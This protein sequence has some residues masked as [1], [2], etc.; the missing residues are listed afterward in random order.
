[1]ANPVDI[2]LIERLKSQKWG[3]VASTLFRL[4]ERQANILLAGLEAQPSGK[5][6][7][8]QDPSRWPPGMSSHDIEEAINRVCGCSGCEDCDCVSV[9]NKAKIDAWTTHNSR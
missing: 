2:D 8:P 3:G 9:F 7:K 6:R 5:G 4:T 1:M